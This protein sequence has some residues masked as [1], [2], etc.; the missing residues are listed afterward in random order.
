MFDYTREAIGTT[1]SEIRRFSV[2]YTVLANLVFIAYLIYAICVGAGLIAVNIVLAALVFCYLAFYI[3]TYKTAKKQTKAVRRTVRHWLAWTKILAKALTLGISL[4]GI[5][6]T[7]T[8][9]T[10]ISLIVTTLTCISWVGQVA[11]E[12]VCLYL[13]AKLN[14]FKAAIEADFEG[15]IKIANTVGNVYKRFVGEEPGDIIPQGE[16]SRQRRFLD[17]RVMEKRRQREAESAEKRRFSFFSFG[18]GSGS[19][20]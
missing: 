13:E 2:G 9:T 4:Y 1:I 17:S 5:Y 11:V 12:L 10:P 19:E 3:A 18:K 20:K 15:G 16:Q 6:L 14:L 8:H 7:T